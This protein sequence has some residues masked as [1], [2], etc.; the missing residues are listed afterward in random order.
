MWNSDINTTRHYTYAHTLDKF[1]FYISCMFSFC[2][3]RFASC[4]PPYLIIPFILCTSLSALSIYALL[5]FLCYI[6]ALFYLIRTW[7]YTFGFIHVYF[8]GMRT[9]VIWI[10]LHVLHKTWSYYCITSFITTGISN[11][12]FWT[13]RFEV[14]LCEGWVRP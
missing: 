10:I 3:S 5:S 2:S 8:M 7:I 9:C 6:I 4:L 11:G 14:F 12:P 1:C 13:Q